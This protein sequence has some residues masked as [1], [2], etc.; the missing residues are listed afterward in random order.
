M[1][2][3]DAK[4]HFETGFRP[5]ANKAFRGL[6]IGQFLA[7]NLTLFQC[8][9]GPIFAQSFA[10]GFTSAHRISM[11]TCDCTV[12][13]YWMPWSLQNSAQAF[14]APGQ[15]GSNTSS[16]AMIPPETIRL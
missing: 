15:F 6:S 1:V 8:Q 7:F 3:I 9:M 2:V 4:T 13:W 11:Q 16:N 12:G 10:A 14:K 5:L